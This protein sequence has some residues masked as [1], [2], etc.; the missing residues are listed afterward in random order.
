MFSSQ[1]VGLLTLLAYSFLTSQEVVVVVVALSWHW[2]KPLLLLLLPLLSPKVM[3]KK[4]NGFP[5]THTQ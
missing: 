2:E 1:L 3:K 5:C 4:Q